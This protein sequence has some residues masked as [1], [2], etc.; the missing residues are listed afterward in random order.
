ML[1]EF[2]FLR[3]PAIRGGRWGE[4]NKFLPP[5]NNSNARKSRTE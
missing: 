4:M 5:S 1:L 2:A 3:N